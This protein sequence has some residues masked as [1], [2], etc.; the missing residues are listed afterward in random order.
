MTEKETEAQLIAR[1][2]DGDEKA[3]SSLVTKYKDRLF[4]IASG[5]C[6]YAFGNGRCGAGSFTF[7]P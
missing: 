6:V 2:K 1:A 7:R 3:L 4:G 5:L